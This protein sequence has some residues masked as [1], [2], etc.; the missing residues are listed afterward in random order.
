[1]SR[2]FLY[3]FRVLFAIMFFC[4]AA[5]AQQNFPDA[6]YITR[7]DSIR[8]NFPRE[9]LH[10]HLDKAIYAPQ[11]TLWF[12]A[13]LVDASSLQ[14]SKVSG[15]IYFEMFDASGNNIQRICLPTAVG[16][17]WGGFA[18]KSDNY[19]AGTYT[20]RAYTNWMLNFGSEY[21]FKK[22]IK[23]VD[24]LTAEDTYQEDK[25]I[26]KSAVKNYSTSKEKA[27]D[28]DIQFLPEGGNWIAGRNQKV[29][30][31]A[32]NNIGKGIKVSGEIIDSR[33]NSV[34]AFQSNDKGMGYF[35]IMANDD[36]NYS[37]II[38]TGETTKKQSLPGISKSG[39]FLQVNNNYGADSLLVNMFSDLPDQEITM[40][41]QSRGVLCFLARFRSGKKYNTLKIAKNLFPTGVCQIYLADEKNK[42]L[43]QRNFYINHKDALQVEGLP[44]KSVYGNRDSICIDIKAIDFL[45]NPISGSFSIA[46]TDDNQVEKDS[47]NN[48]NILSRFLLTADLKGTIENPG[49][50][51]NN[52]K[53][54]KHN[55]LEALMLTQGWVN[56]NWESNKKPVSKAEKDFSI[57]G[58]VTNMVNK[59]GVNAQVLLLG[60]KK[61][62]SITE[63]TTNENGE[64]IF[65]N[66]PALDSAAYVIQVKNS[67]GRAGTLGFEINNPQ[68][69][70]F[71]PEVIKKQFIAEA[72]DSIANNFI[73]TKNKEYQAAYKNGIILREVKITGKHII[74]GSKNLNGEGNADITMTQDELN[75]VAKKTLLQIFEEKLKGFHRAVIPKTS[76]Q[77]YKVNSSFF[78]LII[79]GME[80]DYFFNPT[81]PN[82]TTEYYEYIKSYLDYYNAEDIK[83]IE[84]MTSNKNVN[85]YLVEY[86]SPF[87]MNTYVYAEVT[88]RSGSGP[89]LRKSSNMYRFLPPAYGDNKVFYSPKY[90]LAN[91]EDKAPDYRSTIYWNPHLLTNEKGEA[92]F[93]FFSADKKGS[94]TV[95]IEGSD[96]NGNFGFKTMKLEI[97]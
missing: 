70:P 57:S 81:I 59:P 86:D 62:I 43:S 76:F 30:F 74:K 50:Y 10:I 64:F 61:P 66:F 27:S 21:I 65:K 87:T 15:L 8:K 90:T 68:M 44:N 52:F 6:K 13:Y 24:F 11:D 89:F 77:L 79:D 80:V 26:P 37:A 93:S 33:Q 38:K 22:E 97:K 73:A 1:M 94:Y 39:T 40:I 2:F 4:T 42:T 63:T 84:I 18:L 36:E 9:K 60:T 83:G 7:F 25:K 45:N 14:A 46:I 35:T 31:K 58:R 12:K 49:Y 91:K 48:D 3:T 34:L 17:T 51:F 41:A 53:E 47:I 82:S 56:Y 69:P 72:P 75:K 23:I 20:L 5:L 67:K 78:K 16:L 29:A 19:K 95:W 96:M 28:F 85:K 88:T 54:E 32:I 55:D 71:I 92:S